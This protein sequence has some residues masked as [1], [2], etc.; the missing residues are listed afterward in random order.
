M[1]YYVKPGINA[2]SGVRG[3]SDW[4][5]QVEIG[6][7]NTTCFNALIWTIFQV[8][9]YFL[10][11]QCFSVFVFVVA[12]HLYMDEPD[13]KEASLARKINLTTFP[14]FTGYTQD[15]F[16]LFNPNVKHFLINQDS[17]SVN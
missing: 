2:T 4:R 13:G 15:S 5:G 10:A 1:H 12:P 9:I 11:F 14:T 8:V 3:V 7:E 16:S 6:Q 17:Q